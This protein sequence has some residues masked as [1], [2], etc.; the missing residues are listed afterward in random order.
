MTDPD[1]WVARGAGATTHTEPGGE[2]PAASGNDFEITGPQSM[3]WNEWR[4]KSARVGCGTT[5][6]KVTDFPHLGQFSPI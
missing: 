6:A 3:H 1:V 5:A 2:L 4:A